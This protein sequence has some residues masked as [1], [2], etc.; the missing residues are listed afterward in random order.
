MEENPPYLFLPVLADAPAPRVTVTADVDGAVIDVTV[1]GDWGPH[2]GARVAQEIG[3]CLAESP[4]AIL[5]DAAAVVDPAAESVPVW[6]SATQIAAA[7]DP[8]A[9]LALCVRSGSALANRLG[10]IGARRYLSVVNSTAEARES[11]AGHRP[12]TDVV[13]LRLP[14]SP[15]SPSVARNLI[16]GACQ[17]W[18]LSRLLHPG[19]AVLS[20]LV[21]NAVEHARTEMEVSVSR[22][23]T[24]LHLAVRDRDPTLPRMIDPRPVDPGLPLNERGHGL[25]VV[26][27]DSVAWGAIPTAGGKLVWATVRDRAGRRRR[28]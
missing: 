22:R 3:R 28:W 26:H 16:G 15:V 6:L 11:L 21:S 12:L 24:A 4:A 1:R 10:Q 27:A 18:N 5:I 2:L 13:R 14:P 20:E 23:G 25:R 9:R 7:A 17:A 19:R 8:P